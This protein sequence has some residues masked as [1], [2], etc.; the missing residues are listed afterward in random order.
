MPRSNVIGLRLGI[1]LL[2]A[3]A[4]RLCTA[5]PPRL[6][7]QHLSTREGFSEIYNPFIFRDFKG[8]VWFGSDA[9]VGRHNGQHIEMLSSHGIV[10]YK[11]SSPF[12]EDTLH[13]LLWFSTD[14]AVNFYR[15]K[16][17]DFAHLQPPSASVY[18]CKLLHVEIASGRIWVAANDQ[19]WRA[20]PS[21][22]RADASKYQWQQC[23]SLPTVANFWPMAEARSGEL[24]GLLAT[25]DS[26]EKGGVDELRFRQGSI[27]LERTHLAG[28]KGQTVT[29]AWAESPDRVWL[30]THQG[31]VCYDLAQQRVVFSDLKIG[32]TFDL[33]RYDATRFLLATATGIWLY[34]TK[35]QRTEQKYQNDPNDP[36]SLITNEI[37]RLH[38]DFDRTLWVSTWEG[39]DY[40]NFK[41]VKF[42]TIPNAAFG[43]R[44]VPKS[45]AKAPKGGLFFGSDFSAGLWQRDAAAQVRTLP[46]PLNVSLLCP[47]SDTEFLLS[48]DPNSDK[49]SAGSA[50]YDHASGK[51]WPIVVEDGTSPPMTVFCRLRDGRLLAGGSAGLFQLRKSGAVVRADLLDASF[52]KTTLLVEDSAG[53]LWVGHGG[54]AIVALE[55]RDGNRNSPQRLTVNGTPKTFAETADFLWFGGE[56]G[57]LRVDKS[58]PNATRL[59]GTQDGLPNSKVYGALADAR[60]DLWLSTNHGLALFSAADSTFHAFNLADGLQG[61]EFNTHS[62]C[63]AADGYFWFGGMGGFNRF[64]PDSIRAKMLGTEPFL[65]LNDLKINYKP[66]REV[67][68]SAPANPDDLPNIL[69]KL[70]HN[71]NNLQFTCSA[72]EFSD[73]DNQLIL[74]QLTNADEQPNE[75]KWV[76]VPGAHA[77]VRYDQLSPGRYQLYVQATNSDGIRRK[78]PLI[79]QI[80]IVPPIYQQ[81]WFLVVTALIALL[82]GYFYT[83]RQFKHQ[84]RWQQLLLIEKDFEI[85]KL[86]ALDAEKKRIADEMHDDLGSALTTIIKML[87]RLFDDPALGAVKGSL[88][89]ISDNAQ[90]AI[91]NMRHIIWAL[92]NK[93]DTLAA[94]LAYLVETSAKFLKDNGISMEADTLSSPPDAMLTG[95]QRRRVFLA[96]QEALHNVVKYAQATRVSIRFEHPPGNVIKIELR[97]NGIGLPDN[98]IPG[99]GTTTLRENMEAVGGSTEVR[100]LG[101]GKGTQVT[102]RFPFEP[103]PPKI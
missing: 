27:A 36:N 72:L 83:R 31:L 30:S 50:W 78:K 25:D 45:L 37:Y 44:F 21:G 85:Q 77:I 41:K 61:F 40:A 59:F 65:R 39:V 91:T 49:K 56:F 10:G 17:N 96:V 12:L 54:E 101:E 69:L 60:G 97:D 63:H 94:T 74:Y 5:Q 42:E 76:R 84:L 32:K 35:N 47:I 90:L 23:G 9:G 1:L 46:L 81:P 93:G 38:L 71:E 102:F 48:V 98:Y 28:L 86:L 34:N 55:M 64:H 43:E 22:D 57:L 88:K 16:T 11:V 18:G 15:R 29:K 79:M 33:T 95:G 6:F 53:R 4:A 7:F 82:A 52:P 80:L 26:R 8:T 99:R 13:G 3:V 103:S 66:Y 51:S 89:D 62:Y 24:L 73:P 20:D 2:A 19:L 87:E 70:N 67:L 14:K 92:E 68:P 58:N 75:N 100:S